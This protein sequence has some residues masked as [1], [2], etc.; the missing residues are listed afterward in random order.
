MLS[1]KQRLFKQKDFEAILSD[2]NRGSSQYFTVYYKKNELRFSRFAFSVG[3]KTSKKA[4]S[5]NRIKRTQRESIR[6]NLLLIK[7]GYDCVFI[8]KKDAI[9]LKKTEDVWWQ[10]EKIFKKQGLL[11]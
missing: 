10:I 7:K 3:K 5:R 11:M 2:G 1:K 9:L 6:K 8:A 4:S